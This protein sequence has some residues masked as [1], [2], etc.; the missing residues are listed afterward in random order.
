M[1]LTDENGGKWQEIPCAQT[2]IQ[3]LAKQQDIRFFKVQNQN[4]TKKES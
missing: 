2:A 4:E 3:E 1:K